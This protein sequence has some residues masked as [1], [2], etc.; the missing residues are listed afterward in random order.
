MKHLSSLLLLPLFINPALATDCPAGAPSCKI[1]VLTP[2]EERVLVD[3]RGIL[4]TA[5]QARQLD[6]FGLVAHFRQKISTA[7]A[8]TVV[9]AP[10]PVPVPT[11]D[12]R[13]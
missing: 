5:A 2:E 7:P 9:A 3:P 13:K 1:L 4:D 12:P 11:P 8:G 6:L 10:E